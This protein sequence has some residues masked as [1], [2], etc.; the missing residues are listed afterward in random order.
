MAELSANQVAQLSSAVATAV[1]QALSQSSNEA[2][3]RSTSTNRRSVCTATGRVAINRTTIS[4]SSSTS[5]SNN[6]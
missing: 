6:R 4:T 1:T 2:D 5:N 3:G